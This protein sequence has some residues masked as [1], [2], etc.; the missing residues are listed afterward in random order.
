VGNTTLSILPLGVLL[1]WGEPS[2]PSA[3]A[4]I[5]LGALAYLVLDWRRPDSISRMAVGRLA[6]HEKSPDESSRLR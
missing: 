3:A 2:L 4:A 1:A 5:S 6:L